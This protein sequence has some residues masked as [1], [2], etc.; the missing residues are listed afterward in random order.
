MAIH[1]D[2]ADV[3]CIKKLLH[4]VLHKKIGSNGSISWVPS[5]EHIVKVL[6]NLGTLFFVIMIVERIW[7]EIKCVN[8]LQ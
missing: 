1:K 7:L 4:H 8:V 5:L 3:A 6:I 2:S